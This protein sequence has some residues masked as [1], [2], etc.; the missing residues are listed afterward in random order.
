MLPACLA[1]AAPAL[2]GT[3]GHDLARQLIC[4]VWGFD[5]RL[6]SESDGA[7]SQQL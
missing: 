3:G 4:Q 6:K 2:P 5:G 1:A 7:P